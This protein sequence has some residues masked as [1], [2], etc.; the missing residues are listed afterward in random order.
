MS[1][2]QQEV[3]MTVQVP[4]DLQDAFM[5]RVKEENKPASHIILELMRNYAGRRGNID[6]QERAKREKDMKEAYASV[7]MEGFEVPEVGR[8]LAQ[9]YIDGK[10][11]MQ[12]EIAL[13]RLYCGLPAELDGYK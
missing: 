5:A 1:T 3:T 6:E 8:V 12:E 10:I 11:T 13:G 4:V 2:M 7:H 9:L